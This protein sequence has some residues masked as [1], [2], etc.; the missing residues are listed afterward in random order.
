M[1]N[2][3]CVIRNAVA[4]WFKVD[5]QG[6]KRRERCYDTARRLSSGLRGT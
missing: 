3:G 4:S 5:T 6:V 2:E 1:I